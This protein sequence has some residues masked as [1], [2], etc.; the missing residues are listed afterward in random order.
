MRQ[1][2]CCALL[3]PV[4][5][6]A[7]TRTDSVF[8]ITGDV[9][10]LAEKSEVFLT[11]ANNAKDTITK[12]FVKGGIFVLKGHLPEPNIVELNFGSA[13]KKAVLFMGNDK[14]GLS[15]NVEDLKELK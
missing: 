10:G 5:A 9:K 2:L 8:T 3:L 14:I 4:F 12:G 1:F 7:Q 15:G 13:K 11:D 6:G